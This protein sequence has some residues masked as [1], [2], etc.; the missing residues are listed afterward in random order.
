MLKYRNIYSGEVLLSL[1]VFVSV[2]G[3]AVSM[4][5][6]SSEARYTMLSSR[7]RVECP[8]LLLAWHLVDLGNQYAV[9]RSRGWTWPK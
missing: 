8:I 1:V 7:G 2:L 6:L 5:W 3:E 9:S 4:V